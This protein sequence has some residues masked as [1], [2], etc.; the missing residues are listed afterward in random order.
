MSRRRLLLLAAGGVLAA[1]CAGTPATTATDDAAAT[2]SP[3]ATSTPSDEP[4]IEPGADATSP[5]ATTEACGPVAQPQVQSGG[6]LVGDTDPPVPYSSTPPTSG[7]HA[8]GR[9]ETAVY[10]VELTDPQI[11][12]V[13]EA[14][15][16]VVTYD[17]AV[18][19]EA[20]VAVLVQLAEGPLAERLAVTPYS[21][22]TEAPVMLAAWGHLQA[23][24]SVDAAAVEAFVAEHEGLSEGH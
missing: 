18:V 21:A 11:V 1:G 7:W 8:S 19:A 12:S 5:A 13:L 22:D 23:C 20:D 6:H 3:A 14:G 16:I 9:V 17:P 4:T 24:R 2:S 10:D 15:D